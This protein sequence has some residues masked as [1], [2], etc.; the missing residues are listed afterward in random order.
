MTRHRSLPFAAVLAFLQAL[1]WLP[2][3]INKIS[4]VAFAAES[5]GYR[6]FH[7]YR[8][9]HGDKSG[10]W[11]PQGQ[12]LGVI[13]EFGQHLLDWGGVSGLRERIDFF[14]YGTLAFNTL[15]FG[16][17]AWGLGRALPA[18]WR[19]RLLWA[20]TGLFA[21]YGSWWGQF[22]ACLPDYYACEV[23]LTASCLGLFILWH[24][25]PDFRMSSVRAVALGALA[26]AMVGIKITLLPA[27]L[28]PLLP[29]LMR[30]EG[31]WQQWWR[32]LGL[33][34]AA[35]A[36]TIGA[37][38][39]IYYQFDFG[40]LA[41]AFHAWRSFVSA[42]GAEPGFVTSLLH[43][44]AAGNNPWADH[45]FVPVIFILWLAALAGLARAFFT[46][47]ARRREH[48]VLGLFVLACSALHLWAVF[49]RP[50]ET[51]L[52][53]TALFLSAAAAA[54]LASLPARPA[55]QKATT[56][57][58]SL[59][60]GWCLVSGLQHFPSAATITSMQDTSRNAWEI[61]GWLNA[62]GRPIVVLLPDNRYVSGT[63]EETL[64]K[65]FSDVPTWNITSG[66]ALLDTVAP[67]RLF[68]T[69]IS[70][71][72]AG[73]VL[74]WTDLPD[75]GPLVDLA[76]TPRVV[77]GRIPQQVRS[78]QMRSKQFRPRTVHAAVFAP[79]DDAVN[80]TVIKG[81]SGWRDS[82]PA[83]PLAG[84]AISP[85][86]AAP[87]IELRSDGGRQ[88]VRITATK[89]TSYL[90]LS[91]TIPP[92]PD[93]SGPLRVRATVRVGSPRLALWQIYDVV[94]AQ[95]TAETV[96]EPVTARPVEWTSWSIQKPRIMYASPTDNF[97]VGI[98]GVHP[99]D[100]FEVAELTLL[101]KS[102][103][104]PA[105]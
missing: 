60:F 97:S 100:W 105:P 40:H 77:L 25:Q 3:L 93:G 30:P 54:A 90:A 45:R 79:A 13:H 86:D 95:G 22:S 71:A 17:V 5:V 78:W 31:S 69:Q 47:A 85:G 62:T 89:P 102:A 48:L 84:F 23:T 19:P 42:P 4:P 36:A 66:Y 99:G 87:R 65:G 96:V 72:P 75:A 55:Y 59:A 83:D 103:P 21:V 58:L 39:A 98:V 14:S 70:D 49:K 16:A 80:E 24:Q 37:V 46:D 61:H 2:L 29:C 74:L 88:V 51:T 63:V 41:Q 53:E 12:T 57:W 9:L 28:L 64:L 20:A 52:F 26:G 11:L 44:F 27:A 34:V 76:R 1:P 81:A 50:A 68:V 7:S 94:D 10:L 18:G 56:L 67:R 91:G 43:P 8:L 104:R 82:R 92:L 35:V 6:Y 73:S 33:W 101:L 38:I 32:W 15:V